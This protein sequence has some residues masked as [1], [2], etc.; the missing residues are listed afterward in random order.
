MPRKRDSVLDRVKFRGADALS[1][2][3]EGIEPM[4]VKSKLERNYQ[5]FFLTRNSW[6]VNFGIVR[7]HYQ[8]LANYLVLI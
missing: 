1:L 8:H 4:L 7:K 3:G 6:K 5:F 2:D